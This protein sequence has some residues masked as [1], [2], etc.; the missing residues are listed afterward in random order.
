MTTFLG[1]K[2]TETPTADE[3]GIALRTVHTEYNGY[4]Y[5][6]VHANGAV[7]AFQACVVDEAGEMTPITATL[8]A[9]DHLVAVPQVAF[10]DNDYGWALVKGTGSVNVA[11]N[12]AANV[13]L[14]ATATAGR[15]DDAATANEI[16]GIRLTAAAG[17]AAADVACYFDHPHVVIGTFA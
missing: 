2:V 13:A 14:Y 16:A 12:C 3:D 7:S 10:A 5:M 4:E 15:L 6:K 8:A 9:A 1:P 17:G 11:A